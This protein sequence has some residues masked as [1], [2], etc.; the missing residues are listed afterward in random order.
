MDP[1]IYTN[2]EQRYTKEMTEQGGIFPANVFM[3]QKPVA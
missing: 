2:L 3:A 1:V